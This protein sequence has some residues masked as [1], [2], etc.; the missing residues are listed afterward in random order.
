MKSLLL[1]IM[2]LTAS[3]LFAQGYISLGAGYSM[4]KAAAA[5]LNVGYNLKSLVFQGGYVTHINRRDAAVFNLRTGVAV[6]LTDDA[7]VYITGGAAWQLVSTDN[8]SQNLLSYIVGAELVRQFTYN[9]A[10]TISIQHTAG[11][12]FGVAGVRYYF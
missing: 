10:W 6:R 9:G 7:S 1:S 11:H 2:L 12:L 5:E 4:G 8:K 3:T